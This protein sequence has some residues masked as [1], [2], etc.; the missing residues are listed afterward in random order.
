MKTYHHFHELPISSIKPKGWTRNF[1]QRQKDGLTGHLEVAGRP[2]NTNMWLDSKIQA[3]EGATHM[4]WPYEQTSYLIDGMFRCGVLLDDDYLVNRAKEQ[5]DFVLEHPDE[6]GYLGPEFMKEA[7]NW[8]RWPHAVLFRACMAYYDATEDPQ[9]LNSMK[10]HFLS[11]T[12]SHA[13]GRDVCNI[14]AILWLYEKTGDNT[15]LQ[16]GVT[17]Y[18]EYLHAPLAE[19]GDYQPQALHGVTYNEISKLGSILYLY[20][21]EKQYLDKSI[22][23]YNYL[24]EQC[25][26]ADGL[27]SSTE[28]LRGKDSLDSH[29]TCDI[30]DYTWSA[31]Y[32]LM[33]TGKAKYADKIEKVIYN[34]LPGAVTSDFKALQYFSCGNQVIADSTSNHNLYMRGTQVMSYRPMPGTECCSA[35]VNRAMPN[36]I[37]RMW[38]KTKNNGLA[39]VLYGAGSVNCK[40]GV[41]NQFLKVTEETEYPFNDQI[42]F[43]FNME[44]PCEFDFAFRIPVWCVRP[45]VFV[46]DKRLDKELAA[47]SF[48]TITRCFED[49]DIISLKLP[50]DICVRNWDDGGVSV[51]RGPLV[52]SLKIDEK[53]ERVGD[54]LSSDE[55]PA[56]SIYPASPWNYALDGDHIADKIK[57]EHRRVDDNPWTC[58]SAPVIMKLD[59]RRVP[60]WELERK[61][62]FFCEYYKNGYKQGYIENEQEIVLTPGLPSSEQLDSCINDPTEEITLVPYGCTNLRITVFPK[63]EHK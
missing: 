59:A 56:W 23:R 21:G 50:M 15:L 5:M 18:L 11:G 39:A 30:T 36:F 57:L 26:L 3:A 33:A 24:E 2:F 29:E 25:E 44:N 40:V 49:G 43:V 47:G 27:H 54:V 61:K 14:E 6:E 34:A 55:F 48:N 22:K 58:D 28:I 10:R 60:G 13:D 31:G 19:M 12:A 42:R 37:S 63:T 53:W 8:N 41:N 38:M 4:W 32:M 16:H 52:Y 46:N 45:E 9:I 1:L 20:T 62:K 51:E 35:N 17:A 7:S